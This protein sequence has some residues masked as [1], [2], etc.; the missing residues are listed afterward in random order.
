MI[1]RLGLLLLSLIF[2]W[3][4]TVN[5]ADPVAAKAAEKPQFMF[6]QSAKSVAYH[7]G[8][9]TLKG[10]APATVFFSDRPD[11]IVGHMTTAD[12][13]PFWSKGQDSFL[14]D[15]PNASLSVFQA[16]AEP[17]V[18]E[19]TLKNPQLSGSDLTY[20]VTLLSGQV[21]AQGAEATLFIDI[22]GMPLT[23]YSYAG[24]DRRYYRRY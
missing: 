24:A 21:P 23:P 1:N 20:E 4:P 3:L 22:I 6:V 18:V 16:N 8:K 5:A 7:D 10:V 14:K 17:A 9:L 2:V 13:I 12:F 15:N 11:R 19:V